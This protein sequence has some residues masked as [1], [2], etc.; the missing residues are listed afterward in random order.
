MLKEFR[1]FVSRGNMLDLAIGVVIGAAFGKVTEG[2]MNFIINPLVGLIGGTDFSNLFVV[3]KEG[4]TPGPYNSLK[5]AT[6]AG[7]S[8]LGYG[9]FISAF[10]NFLIVAFVMFMVIKAYNK[11]KKGEA[12]AVLAPPADVALLTE[13]RDLLA[14]N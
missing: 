9:A 10:I 3:L 1:D 7:A 14:K 13:I 6:D 2:F 11:F 8:A 4:K 12:E 5:A